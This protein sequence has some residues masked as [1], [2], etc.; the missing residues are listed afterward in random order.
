MKEQYHLFCLASIFLTF[1]QLT[2]DTIILNNGETIDGQ[3]LKVTETTVIIEVQTEKEFATSTLS[4]SREEVKT[5]I[6]ESQL[7]LF[8]DNR[9]RVKDLSD[10]YSAANPYKQVHTSGS[11]TLVTEDGQVI[12]GNIKSITVSHVTFSRGNDSSKLY[13]ILIDKIVAIN[14]QDLNA[15]RNKIREN[16][17]PPAQK[18]YSYPRMGIEIG[19]SAV[20]N[21]LT[22]YQ[23]TF[24][25]LAQD[26][27]LNSYQRPHAI[28][29]P[30]FTVNL[31]FLIRISRQVS[32][33]ARSH[34]TLGFGD[35]EDFSE[36]SEKFRLFFAE[37]QYLYPLKSFSP[38]IGAGFAFQS[39][40]IINRYNNVDAKYKSQATSISLAAGFDLDVNTQLNFVFALRYLPFGEKGINI[41]STG[42][43]TDGYR[44][45]LSNLMISAGFVV[46]L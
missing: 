37:V 18:V 41:E 1:L 35:N 10:Y 28:D 43:T 32:L 25:D 8:D 20:F 36:D 31:G 13:T 11:D 34:F 39:V 17:P 23:N 15:I 12:I 42:V 24:D 22:G 7:K 9:L 45:D 6:D 5:I 46:N 29:N 33:A 3:T 44:I 21:Q 26:L 38:W 4:V 14:D 16:T 2:A 30:I 27:D 40:T 19:L